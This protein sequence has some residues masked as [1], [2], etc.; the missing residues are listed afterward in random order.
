MR[1]VACQGKH[2][3]A[4]NLKLRPDKRYSTASIAMGFLLSLAALANSKFTTDRASI[5]NPI[6]E[7][8]RDLGRNVLRA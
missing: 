4:S 6:V 2:G 1:S 7:A 3:G 5:D 8:C